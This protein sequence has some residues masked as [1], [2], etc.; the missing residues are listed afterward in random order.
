MRCSERARLS[1]PLLRASFFPHRAAVALAVPIAELGVVT[2]K[3]N[4]ELGD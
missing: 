2:R 1:R 4:Q 3:D